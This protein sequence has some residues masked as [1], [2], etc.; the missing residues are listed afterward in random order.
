MKKT[1]KFVLLI[2]T[3]PLS[4]V[5]VTPINTH[6][7]ETQNNFTEESK[8]NNSHISQKDLKELLKSAKENPNIHVET[9]GDDFTIVIPDSLLGNQSNT[10]TRAA[11]TSKVE[12]KISSGNFKVYL[13][14]NALNAI[15]TGGASFVASFI[16]GFGGKLASFLAGV[17]ASNSPY[18]HGRV[19][20]YRNHAY[21]YWYYQ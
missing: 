20:V 12:G 4:F 9:N 21:Q 19:F 6:A 15:R 18:Y 17:I 2:A 13:S 16:P 11:G 7:I 5:A 3:I 1:N 10:L 8:E 14:K